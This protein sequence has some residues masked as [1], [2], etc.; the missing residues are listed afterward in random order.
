[1]YAGMSQC[2][3]LQSPAVFPLRAGLTILLQ[4]DLQDCISTGVKGTCFDLT[5]GRA[6][7]PRGIGRLWTPLQCSLC[8]RTLKKIAIMTHFWFRNSSLEVGWDHFFFQCSASWE[9]LQKGPQAPCTLWRA[10]MT[11][12]KVTTS[13]F[14]FHWRHNPGDHCHSN[15]R[16]TP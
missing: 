12:G 10:D 6:S 16:L 13:P 4:H 7:S 9:A 1:M 8:F 15:S 5:W 3:K 2:P 14:V 11:P